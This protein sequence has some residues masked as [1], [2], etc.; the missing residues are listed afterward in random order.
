MKP[1][2]LFIFGLLVFFLAC[3]GKMDTANKLYS[4]ASQLNKI[5]S[6]GRALEK[7]DSAIRLDSTNLDYKLL[8]AR[9]LK[10]SKNYEE[11]IAVL[12]SLEEKKFKLDTIYF[13]IGSNYFAKG[14]TDFD[15]DESDSFY[16]NAIKYSSLSININ[17]NL[18]VSHEMRI[19]S[20]HNLKNYTEALKFINTALSS[21]PKNVELTLDRGIERQM[22][23]DNKGAFTD[24]KQSISSGQLDSS[25][26]GTAYR[27]L[28]IIKEEEKDFM[29][30]LDSYSQAIKFDSSN[31]FLFNNRGNCFKQM[32]QREKACADFRKAA[33]LGYVKVYEIIKNYCN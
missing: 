10:K 4:Q 32:G 22:L 6:V 3:E 12:H 28:G 19:R 25:N 13:E 31:Y 21:F 9:V 7:I 1:P 23:G 17:S 8:R 33:D 27:W 26:L 5:D 29:S 16:T 30:A 2:N 20:S 15:E 11:S 14:R 18:F 24:I